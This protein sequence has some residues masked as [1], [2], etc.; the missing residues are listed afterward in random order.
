VLL[1]HIQYRLH[2]ARAGKFSATV[3]YD[4]EKG[5]FQGGREKESLGAKGQEK[6]NQ[7]LTGRPE[8]G[9]AGNGLPGRPQ[10]GLLGGCRYFSPFFMKTFGVF[11]SCLDVLGSQS[12]RKFMTSLVANLRLK[13]A[14]ELDDG[15]HDAG[16][17]GP[18]A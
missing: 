6:T 11:L 12:R 7:H 18:C 14:V 5:I 3:H 16:V 4:T 1:I 15:V 10:K 17:L 13:I 8:A 2:P 9:D